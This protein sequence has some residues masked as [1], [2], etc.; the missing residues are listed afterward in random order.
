LGPGFRR[1]EEIGEWPEDNGSQEISQEEGRSAKIRGEENAKK[2]TIIHLSQFCHVS[3]LATGQ[4]IPILQ[5]HETRLP[6]QE[7]RKK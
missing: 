5:V 2:E 4:R 3:I 1:Q 6:R 7:A